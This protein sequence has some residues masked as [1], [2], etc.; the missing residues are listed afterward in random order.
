MTTTWV[1][2]QRRCWDFNHMLNSPKNRFY[3]RSQT[4]PI[5]DVLDVRLIR[6]DTFDKTFVLNFQ[7]FYKNI[8]TKNIPRKLNKKI[9]LSKYNNK[10]QK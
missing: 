8:A 4:E 10:N 2:H 5:L 3:S 9:F 1:G 6:F 7:Q